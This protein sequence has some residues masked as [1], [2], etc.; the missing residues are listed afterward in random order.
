VKP[1]RP[2]VQEN[3][4]IGVLA[5]VAAVPLTVLAIT[6]DD[7]LLLA[8]L[9]VITIVWA[10]W[11][12]SLLYTET[13]APQLALARELPPGAFESPARMVLRCVALVLL[14]AAPL[15]PLG[16]AMGFFCVVAGAELGQ[17]IA[18]LAVA[19]RLARW[20]REH[21]ARIG[22]S[23]LRRLERAEIGVRPRSRTP[24]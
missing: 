18:T 5:L 20:E 21:D 9:P 24:P 22:R 8:T 19:V 6:H 11:M 13:I 10:A 3:V 23:A 2:L 4:A 17:G 16:I 12:Y 1:Y 7:S 15:V 14:T